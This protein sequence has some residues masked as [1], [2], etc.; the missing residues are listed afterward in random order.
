ML[1]EPARTSPHQPALS[2]AQVSFVNSICTTKGGTHVLH[3][4]DQFVD[5]IH[6]KAN[7]KNKGGMDIKPYHVRA[8]AVVSSGPGGWGGG[9]VGEANLS[10]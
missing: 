7:A 10:G 9:G 5:A 2:T 1:H 3:V 6:K 4:A 8:S